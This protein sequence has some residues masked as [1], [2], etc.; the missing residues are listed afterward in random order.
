MGNSQGILVDG[1]DANT[2]GGTTPA[3]R[4]LVAANGSENIF[5]TNNASTNLVV[6]NFVGLSASGTSTVTSSGD[7]VLMDAAADNTVGGTAVGSGNV[8]AGQGGDALQIIGSGGNL[9]QGNLI[10]TDPTGAIPLGDGTDDVGISDS[11]NNL[12]GGTAP[13]AGNTLAAGR[14]GIFLESSMTTAMS[15]RATSLAPMPPAP[16]V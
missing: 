13:G 9:V 2:I 5:L 4:N 12:I 8:I 11:S 3:D 16:P 6:G 15:S 14:N 1:S 10:G 7:G